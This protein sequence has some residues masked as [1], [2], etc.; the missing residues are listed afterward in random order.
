MTATPVKPMKPV[1][2]MD[3]GIIF[4]SISGFYYVADGENIIECKARGRFRK[5]GITPLVGDRVFYSVGK[6]GKGVLETVDARKNSFVRPPVANLEIMVIIA[7]AVIPKTDPFLIDRVVASVSRNNC[8]PVI[9]INKCD[10]VRGEE[11]YDIYSRAGYTTLYTSAKTGEGIESLKKLLEGRVS[12]FTGNSG[13]G[14]SSIIN[15]MEPG[16]NIK[17]GEVSQKLGRGKHTTRHVE[18]FHLNCG[19]IIAD[20]PGFSSFNN[21]QVEFVKKDELQY[22]FKEFE[23]YMGKCRFADCAHIK[24]KGCAVLEA[25]ERGEIS[26]SRHDSYVRLYDQAKQIKEWQMK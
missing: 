16:F 9:C 1:I 22:A 23:P 10:M 8:E 5:E 13:V 24:E 11:L 20:T 25:L 21:E 3:K 18:L 7:S 12:A 26:K 17:V 6:D 4:K 15:A 2:M 14:K 19:A